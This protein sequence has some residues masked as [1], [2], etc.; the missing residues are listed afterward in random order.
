MVMDLKKKRKMEKKI[1]YGRKNEG[2]GSN[3]H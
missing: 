3:D 1:E 2:S